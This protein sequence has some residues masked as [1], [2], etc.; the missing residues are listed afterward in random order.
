MG[1]LR[2]EV[3]DQEQ[4]D[5]QGST[6]AE[7][8]REKQSYINMHKPG[9]GDDDEELKKQK[10]IATRPDLL[11]TRPDLQRGT[12]TVTKANNNQNVINNYSNEK[13]ADP[14]SLENLENKH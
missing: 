4:R 10:T 9:F 1:R 5:S 3:V 6:D 7:K 13:D 2:T 8:D 11:A 12:E 14:Y